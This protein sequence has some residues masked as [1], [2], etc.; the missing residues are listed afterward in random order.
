MCLLACLSKAANSQTVKTRYQNL[1]DTQ[2]PSGTDYKSH[3]DIVIKKALHYRSLNVEK[4]PQRSIGVYTPKRPKPSQGSGGEFQS[5]GIQRRTRP[6]PPQ[7]LRSTPKF[8]AR[9]PDSL[10]K[11]G[12]VKISARQSIS[13]HYRKNTQR[14]RALSRTSTA[15]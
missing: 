3:R 14:S 7:G 1:S 2:K 6:K 11:E 5:G 10:H 12:C 4:P 8:K 13:T 15:I 9:Q